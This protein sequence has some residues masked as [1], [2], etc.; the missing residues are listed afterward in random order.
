MLLLCKWQRWRVTQ[1]T[2][3]GVDASASLLSV[4]VTSPHLAQQSANDS[5]L[6]HQLWLVSPGSGT[7]A[8][9]SEVVA[10]HR[11]IFSRSNCSDHSCLQELRFVS[12]LGYVYG[13]KCNFIVELFMLLTLVM[14]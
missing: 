12:V 3:A 11:G 10:R 13:N 4:L 7:M 2:V 8:T 6:F 14:T 9:H 1:V 5:R